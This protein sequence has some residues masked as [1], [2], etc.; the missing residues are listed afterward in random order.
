MGEIQAAGGAQDGAAQ[1]TAAADPAGAPRGRVKPAPPRG[2]RLTDRRSASSR[3]SGDES[4]IDMVNIDAS[5]SR[6]PDSQTLDDERQQL[7]K[8]GVV[9]KRDDRPSGAQA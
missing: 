6:V 8:L 7:M 5:A 2:P 1:T 9:E 3:L 4:D